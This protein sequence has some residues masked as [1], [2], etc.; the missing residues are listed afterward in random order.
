MHNHSSTFS[1]FLPVIDVSF[2]IAS[3][4]SLEMLYLIP[5]SH[6]Q[7]TM[8]K[9]FTDELLRQSPSND[10]FILDVHRETADPM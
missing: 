2:T 1:P 7:R 5:A 3:I 10:V 6:L 9:V 4:P 8:F